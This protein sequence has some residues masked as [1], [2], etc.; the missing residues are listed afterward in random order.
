MFGAMGRMVLISNYGA[1]P[2][3]ELLDA[4]HRSHGRLLLGI[5]AMA[6]ILE[7]EYYK[8]LKAEFLEALGAFSKRG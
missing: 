5:P 3:G 1:L 2:P 4:V 8:D 6:E 7:E